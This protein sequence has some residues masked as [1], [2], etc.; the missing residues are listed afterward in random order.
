M[1]REALAVVGR[2]WRWGIREAVEATPP[3]ALTRSRIADRWD[4]PWAASA[5]TVALAGDALHPMTP[6]LGQGGGVALEDAVVLSQALAAQPGLVER[7][8]GLAGK[9]GSS[10]GS[11]AAA[12]AGIRAA[13]Q[14]YEAER[15]RR[16]L[17]ITIRSHLMG[18]A[19]QSSVAPVAAARDLVVQ[20]AFRP[21]HFLAHAV[22]DCGAAEV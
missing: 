1:R 19:L 8:A 17:P 14:R 4:P 16:S 5:G 11:R 10:S 9:C 13:V 21:A 18:A 7:V 15:L 6:N 20:R 3:E 2:S 22:Y 12:V